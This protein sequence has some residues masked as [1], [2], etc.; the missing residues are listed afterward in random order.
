MQFE[1]HV[2]SLL[3]SRTQSSSSSPIRANLSTVIVTVTT[4][5]EDLAKRIK[6][7]LDKRSKGRCEILHLEKPVETE[8]IY[9][10]CISLVDLGKPLMPHLNMSQ[11]EGL[12]RIMGIA[13]QFIWVTDGCGMDAQNPEAA[14]M[15]GFGKSLERERPGLSFVHL[16]V[17]TADTAED[18]IMRVV[19][20]SHTLSVEDQETDLLEDKEED[21]RILVPRAVEAPDVNSLLHAAIHGLQPQPTLVSKEGT[22][23]DETLELR[24]NPGRLDSLHFGPDLSTALPLQDDEV[25]V[26]T[27]ATGINFRDVMVALN[28]IADDQIGAEF[29]GVVLEVGAAWQSVWTPGDRVCGPLDG[30]FRTVARTT[31]ATLVRMPP[32]M[33]FAEAAAVPVAFATAQYALRYLARIQPGES[34]LIHAAAGGVGQAAVYLAQ[35]AGATVYAT[36]STPEKKELL[37]DRFGIEA[38]RIFSSRHTLFAS[39][40]LQQSRGRGVDV[41]LNSLAGQALTES[42]RCLAHLGRFVEIG[43]RDVRAFSALPMEPFARNVSFCSLDLKV[44]AQHNP[45]L[46]STIMQEIQAIVSE[47]AGAARARVVPHP[48]TVFKRSGFEE[49]FR[50]LQSGRHAGK[51]VVDWEESDTIEVS[52]QPK[53]RKKERKKRITYSSSPRRLD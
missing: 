5:H 20:Q 50:L 3:V 17:Q 18:T 39:Q 45:A 28:Q 30:S 47:D 38:G 7:R 40:I 9:D 41:V 15:A 34:I 44:L 43:K 48:L 8:M 37:M 16:N 4:A 42:W 27:K 35:R 21:G 25:L 1:R 10:Q 23:P 51:V 24:F 53:E 2:N 26:L 14:M 29:A 49:A 46:L 11:F 19:D 6:A 22:S 32:G 36:V 31:G 12:R 33:S 52:L 13:T